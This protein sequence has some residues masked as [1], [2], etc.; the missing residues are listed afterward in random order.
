MMA[1][2]ALVRVLIHTN[3][4]KYLNFK[5]V[6]GSFVYKKGKVHMCTILFFWENKDISIALR[7]FISL[8]GSWQNII[9]FRFIKFQQLMLKH[10]NQPWW[11]CL[12]NAVL[13]SFSFMSKTMK[14]VTQNLM[15]GW[16]WTKL[17][18]EILSRMLTISHFSF[19]IIALKWL[20][21]RY[22]HF[23]NSYLEKHT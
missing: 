18:Q 5:A 17:Q 4:T 20:H 8:T 13:E 7:T 14:R 11:V 2:G 19:A 1:N 21:H 23:T 10:W 16:I 15:K 6:D 22:S 12:R 3:V 9:I